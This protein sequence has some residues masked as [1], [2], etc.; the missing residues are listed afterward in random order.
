[1]AGRFYSLPLDAISVTNDADQDIWSLGTA[2]TKQLILHE[3]RLTTTNTTDERLRMQLVRR[4]AVGSGGSAVTANALDQGN[5]IAAATTCR[6]L[7]TA[8]G[9]G[10]TIIDCF[11]WG[12][13]GEFLYLPTP[14]TRPVMS[15]SGFLSLHLQT[16]V[17]GTR[18]WSG[19]VKFEEI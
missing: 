14:E 16:A 18:T 1:M 6:V 17:G 4:T 8:P 11:Q 2:S 10:S 19:S 13:Q 15:V 3:F 9:T 12:Q 5:A 7:D